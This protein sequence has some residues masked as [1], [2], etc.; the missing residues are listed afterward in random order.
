MRHLDADGTP[1]GSSA[2][3]AKAN[4]GYLSFPG[5]HLAYARTLDREDAFSQAIT[6]YTH[7]IL[8]DASTAT[9]DVVEEFARA[10]TQRLR[11]NEGVRKFESL[12]EIAEKR[13]LPPNLIGTLHLQ[14]ALLYQPESTRSK[15]RRHLSSAID[16]LGEKPEILRAYVTYYEA[17]NKPEQARI[18]RFKLRQA[19][20]VQKGTTP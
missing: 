6:A 15:V 9:P 4:A 1:N 11:R 2:Q 3:W 17:K 5:Y 7:A 19:E 18:W 12:I 14:T 20:I 13:R 10:Y 16:Y 8:D